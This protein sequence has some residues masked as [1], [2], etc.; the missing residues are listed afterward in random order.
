MA[1]TLFTTI[2][3]QC[4]TTATVI[5]AEREIDHPSSNTS[6]VSYVHFSKGMKLSLIQGRLSSLTS[7]RERK[8]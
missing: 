7:F 6:L 8:V 1:A 4:E 3:K 5:G 2:K